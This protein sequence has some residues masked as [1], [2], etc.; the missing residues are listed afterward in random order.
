MK[1]ICILIAVVTFVAMGL[2]GCFSNEAEIRVFTDST[3][4]Q[5]RILFEDEDG[6]QLIITEYVH[7]LTQYNSINV[8]T[9]LGKSDRL[10]PALNAWF[11][12]T[13]APEL[14]E[15][16]L[17]AENVNN[18]VRLTAEGYGLTAEDDVLKFHAEVVHENGT[19]GWS[20]AGGTASQ[21]SRLFI[22]SISEVNKYVTLGTLNMQGMEYLIEHGLYVPAGWWLRSPGSN[23][24]S[25]V[26]IMS[27][28]DT[29]GARIVA[30]PATE[31]SGFRPALW[32]TRSR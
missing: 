16:A 13:L 29:D 4:V 12:N 17:V 5:W 26:A 11:A 6:Y 3:G 25:P 8:Y 10:G 9:F 30:A 31:K 21:E 23:V 2:S 18:D 1:R 20:V 14:R 19:A 22:L 27:A 32:I 15:V 28:G 24:K 7:G